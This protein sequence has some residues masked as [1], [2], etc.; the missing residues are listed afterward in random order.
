M[1]FFDNAIVEASIKWAVI[2]QTL[3]FMGALL[4]FILIVISLERGR[5]LSFS[6]EPSFLA[7]TIAAS[8]FLRGFTFF[9]NCGFGFCI[10]GSLVFKEVSFL[11]TYWIPCW[12]K[13]EHLPPKKFE[14]SPRATDAK[15]RNLKGTIFIA[16]IMKWLP[17]RG[18]IRR[19]FKE[20]RDIQEKFNGG[21]FHTTAYV[22]STRIGVEEATFKRFPL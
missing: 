4:S 2:M 10:F 3:Y 14:E 20:G 17:F 13:Y 11:F 7:A 16:T 9:F 21:S 5:P 15:G 1:I 6:S 22:L 18:A 8:G 12:R 19:A